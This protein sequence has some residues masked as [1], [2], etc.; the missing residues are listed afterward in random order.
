VDELNVNQ[1]IPRLLTKEVKYRKI[2]N[3]EL[4]TQ[5]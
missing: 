1:P 2:V 3:A 5:M 4:E